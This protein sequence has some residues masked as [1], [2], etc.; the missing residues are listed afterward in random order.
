MAQELEAKFTFIIG[1]AAKAKKLPHMSKIRKTKGES[2]PPT[3]AEKTNQ[4]P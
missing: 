1:A 2:T 4:T 3:E